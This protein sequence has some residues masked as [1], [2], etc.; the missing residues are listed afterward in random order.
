MK[1]RPT[2]LKCK[3]KNNKKPN[4]FSTS[5]SSFLPGAAERSL[6]REP[7]CAVQHEPQVSFPS[8]K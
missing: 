8:G 2:L 1:Q 5:G 3:K 6:K 7:T 4:F